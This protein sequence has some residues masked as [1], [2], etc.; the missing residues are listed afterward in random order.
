MSAVHSALHFDGEAVGDLISVGDKVILF[1]VRVELAELD[2]RLFCSADDA[3][4]AVARMLR[5]GKAQLHRVSA[6]G[7]AYGAMG[8]MALLRPAL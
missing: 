4:A 3:H 8:K 7:A 2:G 1:A 5:I 6:S